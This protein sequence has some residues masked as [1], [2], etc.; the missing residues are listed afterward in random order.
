MRRKIVPL[1]GLLILGLL[2]PS[3]VLAGDTGK[4]MGTITDAR[5]GDPM[6]GANVVLEGTTMGAATDRGGMFVIL[7]VPARS[8]TM[9]VSVV[10]YTT[11]RIENVIAHVDL[12]TFQD[13]QLE[14]TVLEGQIIVVTAARPLVE[15]NVTNTSRI[16]RLEDFL[17]VYC[18]ASP[19]MLSYSSQNFV[20]T[21]RIWIFN[22]MCKRMRIFNT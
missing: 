2:L 10:G 5:T 13:V 8:Y 20:P 4:I 15:R 11:T 7:N 14:E 6:P 19:A 12:T 18:D 1:A 22:S 17:I 16:L 3:L 9:V 21:R